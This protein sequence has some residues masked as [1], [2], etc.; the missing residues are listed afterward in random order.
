M[1]NDAPRSNRPQPRTPA[2]VEAELRRQVRAGLAEARAAADGELTD[3]ALAQVV[4]HAVGQALGWHV[5]APEHARG[6]VAG[7]GWRPA[8]GPRGASGRPDWQERDRPPRR[9]WDDR[10]RPPRGDWDERGGG[11]RERGPRPPRAGYG[12]RPNY[13]N[14][15]PKPGG[16]QKRRPS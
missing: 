16:F 3:E 2:A 15:P 1:D 7:G 14:R 13:G 10:G 11:Y 12:N 8:T 9:D 4:A 6:P 5:D